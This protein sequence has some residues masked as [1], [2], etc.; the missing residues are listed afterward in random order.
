MKLQQ[1]TGQEQ[2]EYAISAY[3]GIDIALGQADPLAVYAAKLEQQH[4]EHMILI[5]AGQF[6]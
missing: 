4:P 1:P 3:Q 6:L 2:S 5:Q